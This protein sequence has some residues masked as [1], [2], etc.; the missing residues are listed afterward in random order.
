VH[1]STTWQI[2]SDLGFTNIL[3][4]LLTSTE[5]LTDFTST[6][7]VPP[8][9]VYYSRA[10]R[11]FTNGTSASW[12]NTEKLVSKSFMSN[13]VTS[14]KIVIDKPI[15][16]V[17]K[18]SLDPSSDNIVVRTSSFKGEY[19]DHISTHWI[20]TNDNGEVCYKSINDTVNLT[21]L[22]IN[23]YINNL[24]DKNELLIFAIHNGNESVESP[25]G[26]TSISLGTF[27]YRILSNTQR[28]LPYNDFVLNIEKI[29]VYAPTHIT[30][31]SLINP[32]TN[33][34]VQELVVTT[35]DTTFTIPGDALSPYAEFYLDIYSIGNNG[36]YNY[37]R[38]L[39]KTIGSYHS[40]AEDSDYVYSKSYESYD[41]TGVSSLVNIPTNFY[42]EELL[43]GY[44][45]SA[46]TLGTRLYKCTYDRLTKLIT[47]GAVYK[48]IG[49][50][51]GA[52]GANDPVSTNH[53]NNI[54][55]KLFDT[56][57]LLLD[58]E[59]TSN[60]SMYPVFTIYRYRP[61]TDDFI[62]ISSTH[63]RSDEFR[64]LGY[65][66]NYLQETATT[67]LYIP[68]KN[69]VIKRLDL[70]TG[71]I[72]I[73]TT[74]PL[75]TDGVNLIFEVNSDMYIVIGSNTPKAYY[76]EPSS[77]IY[78]EA[79]VIPTLFRN[80]HLKANKLINGDVAITIVEPID[81]ND[82]YHG[83]LYFNKAKNQISLIE[84]TTMVDSWYPD[85]N[86][87]LKTGELLLLKGNDSNSKYA[88]LQ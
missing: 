35:D 78:T 41:Y 53:N 46:K 75:D 31:I 17:D 9:T 55:V 4:S 50:R 7:E 51:Y 54:F 63:L 70:S 58:N 52:E 45:I 20:I 62:L 34:A 36:I 26:K 47:M 21:T 30:G 2:A 81:S 11:F 65:T 23:K 86:I 33:E 68:Y 40:E 14:K 76:Y 38:R 15:V 83:V 16:I 77:G 69:N 85:V 42:T 8:N 22:S 59:M 25:L 37:K 74:T 79:F 19:T 28:V 3:D 64:A 5:H 49:L 73:I 57:Y 29:D 6:V 56:N 27:N 80:K 1:E 88:V 67:I 32:I 66:N 44:F 84:T 82:T 43:D 12:T 87:K 72:N 60:G 61:N 13:I 18:A 71:N 24:M 10:K 39:L 48:N